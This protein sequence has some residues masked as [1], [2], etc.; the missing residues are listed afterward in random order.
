MKNIRQVGMA[1]IGEGFS[2]ARKAALDTAIL[3]QLDGMKTQGKLV[4]Y[5]WQITQT[6][7]QEVK[8]IAN[9]RLILHPAFETR[10]L[11]VTVEL[12]QS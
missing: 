8:G 10:R 1:F 4:D 9:I 2:G 3:R 7:A 5:D 11:E 6:A 12:R